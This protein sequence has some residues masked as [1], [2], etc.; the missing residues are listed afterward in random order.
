MY[1]YCKKK[2][3]KKNRKILAMLQLKIQ[4]KVCILK[5][6]LWCALCIIGCLIVQACMIEKQIIWNFWWGTQMHSFLPS[7][8][9]V[10]VHAKFHQLRGI[11]WNFVHVGFFDYFWK[12]ILFLTDKVKSYREVPSDGLCILLLLFSCKI[13]FR[14]ELKKAI[15]V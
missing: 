1:W 6:W 14:N 12:N 8:E 5:Y 2:K 7:T 9:K 15:R 13:T 4:N 11:I 10:L 3:K